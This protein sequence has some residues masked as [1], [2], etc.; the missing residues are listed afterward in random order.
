[1]LRIL[2]TIFVIAL[3]GV[4]IWVA[5]TGT[6]SGSQRGNRSEAP[7]SAYDYEATDV[8]IQQMGADGTL[9]YELEARHIAQLPSNGQISAQDLV[10]HHDP[11]G[12]APGTNRLTLT[13]QRA[14]LPESGDEIT[15]QGAVHAQGRPQNSRALISLTTERI[16]YD[17]RTQDVV[18]SK[19]V[20]FTRGGMRARCGSL[21]GNIKRGEFAMNGTGPV[22]SKCD[23]TFAP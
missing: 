12:S 5:G 20:D 17:M 2:G 8:R 16:V 22:E 23:V 11:A 10:I 4:A 21:R 18:A 7:T 14:D 15:L 9:Q 1:M 19:P 6:R 3:A 13:A